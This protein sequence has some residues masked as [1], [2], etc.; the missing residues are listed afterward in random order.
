M[1]SKRSLD[2]LLRVHRRC[3][4]GALTGVSTSLHKTR[5]CRFFYEWLKE[6]HLPRE[7][8]CGTTAQQIAPWLSTCLQDVPRPCRSSTRTSPGITFS[9]CTAAPRSA[10]R[11]APTAKWMEWSCARRA[12]ASQEC[13]HGH[14]RCSWLAA[15]VYLDE[16]GRSSPPGLVESAGWHATSRCSRRFGSAVRLT[17][18]DRAYSSPT[19]RIGL[20]PPAR[21]Q[22][23]F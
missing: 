2:R 14:P 10:A 1:S 16:S 19:R 8:Q 17:P 9:S 6:R 4:L 12:G 7:R 15:P 11:T 23:G 3:P 21:R 18:G 22:V 5:R 13:G 20:T